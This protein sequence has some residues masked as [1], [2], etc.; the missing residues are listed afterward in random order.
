MNAAVLPAG[1]PVTHVGNG[2]VVYPP[3]PGLAAS[4]Q[5]AIRL[6]SLRSRGEWQPL[7]AWETRCKPIEPRS[8]GYFDA[9]AG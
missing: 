1:M 4:E 2:L 8:D 9:L 3:V 6:R 5:Y 7:F